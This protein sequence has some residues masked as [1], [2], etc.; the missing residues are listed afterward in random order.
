[1]AID[2]LSH[3]QPGK[4]SKQ[5]ILILSSTTGSVFRY[6]SNQGSEEH[7]SSPVLCVMSVFGSSSALTGFG[8]VWAPQWMLFSKT[9]SWLLNNKVAR[10]PHNLP[11]YT[12]SIFASSKGRLISQRDLLKLT[13][14]KGSEFQSLVYFQPSSRYPSKHLSSE[15]S[16][17]FHVVSV[18]I[19]DAPNAR[20]LGRHLD[21]RF[22]GHSESCLCSF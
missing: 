20:V 5:P 15:N 2:S 8:N 11:L 14:I 7:L 19:R 6:H 22:P 4:D 12:V 17:T 10:V 21:R 13:L 3:H 18:L 9:Q 16:P 1:M